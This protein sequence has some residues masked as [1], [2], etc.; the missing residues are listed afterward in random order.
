[1]TRDMTVRRAA[2]AAIALEQ[3]RTAREYVSQVLERELVT[4]QSERIGLLGEM[5]LLNREIE[6]MARDVRVDPP[7]TAP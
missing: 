3:V 7:G 2:E 1:V 4:L 6:A 5:A